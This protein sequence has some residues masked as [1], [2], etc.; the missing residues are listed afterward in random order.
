VA[1]D[2]HLFRQI[3]A[4]TNAD[5]RVITSLLPLGS[6]RLLIGTAKLGLLIYDGKTLKRFHPTTEVMSM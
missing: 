4:R 5:A 2:G 1:F 6:G 3:C